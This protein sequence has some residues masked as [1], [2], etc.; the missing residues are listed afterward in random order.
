MSEIEPRLLQV[1]E[2]LRVTRPGQITGKIDILLHEKHGEDGDYTPLPFDED[3]PYYQRKPK[4]IK[5]MTEINTLTTENLIALS[6]PSWQMR[7]A[8]FL[9]TFLDEPSKMSTSQYQFSRSEE[10][11]DMMNHFASAAAN[12]M[13][14]IQQ[15]KSRMELQLQVLYQFMTQTDNHLHATLAAAAT[16]DSSAM[17][18]LAFLTAL[19]L[20]GTYVATLF[21]MDMFNWSGPKDANGG[22]ETATTTTV[23]SSFWIYWIVTGILT[24]AVIGGWRIWWKK[25]NGRHTE[26]YK[27]FLGM[28]DKKNDERPLED[29][30]TTNGCH[31]A[32]EESEDDDGEENECRGR[33]KLRGG[34]G[35][36]PVNWLLRAGHAL[37]L[38]NGDLRSIRS[39]TDASNEAG[40]S[41]A[42]S[43]LAVDVEAGLER[44]DEMDIDHEPEYEQHPELE[45]QEKIPPKS[46]RRYSHSLSSRHRYPYYLK[47]EPERSASS[48]A[49][50]CTEPV[51]EDTGG[52][53]EAPVLPLPAT[54]PLSPH[55]DPPKHPWTWCIDDSTFNPKPSEVPGTEDFKA[56]AEP[57]LATEQHEVKDSPCSSAATSLM[58]VNSPG[59]V[60]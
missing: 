22:T 41:D 53:A 2:V 48:S 52:D 34:A 28:L 35:S 55:P 58:C 23:S 5:L 36:N 12:N 27:T 30:C 56:L 59:H 15:L 7:F 9:K 37:G 38:E 13:D 26:Q 11:D 10:M 46:R 31:A 32:R 51:L 3:R 44:P 29:D 1:E 25:E 21:S 39:T 24:F 18:T 60:Q 50:S 47:R 17:K 45:L 8:G 16:R 6:V 43:D 19:F 4:M 49:V 42:Q 54:P 20:P 14:H 40:P 33:A 57:R